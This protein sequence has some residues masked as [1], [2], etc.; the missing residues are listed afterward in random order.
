MIQ[1]V[2]RREQSIWFL[3][4]DVWNQKNQAERAAIL[5]ES[6]DDTKGLTEELNFSIFDDIRRSMI[7][8]WKT[9]GNTK[10]QFGILCHEQAKLIN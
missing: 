8:T 6:L 10:E 4:H 9:T 2:E 7:K 1:G 3:S 5:Q